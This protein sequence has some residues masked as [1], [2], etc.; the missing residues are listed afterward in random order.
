MIRVGSGFDAHRFDD[1]RPL[2]L[3]GISIP[4]APGLAGHSDADAVSHAIADALLSA[5]RLGDLGTLF[6]RDERWRDA[7]S[8]D[9]LAQTAE[10]IGDAGWTIVNVDCTVVTETPRIS[11]YR[12]QMIEMLAAALR[13]A[14]SAVWIKATTTDGLGFTGR[15][16]GL[17]AS[18]TAL[19]ERPDRSVP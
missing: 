11:E 1:R 16:E 12:S 3:G 9:M 6:P 2:I 13:V 7:S 5:A 8:L 15:R 17:A 4:N 19:I 10:A 18:A 14:T